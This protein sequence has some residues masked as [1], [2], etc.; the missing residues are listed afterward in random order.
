M[1]YQINRECWVTPLWGIEAVGRVVMV[2]VRTQ[3]ASKQRSLSL[4]WKSGFLVQYCVPCIP[5]LTRSVF[6]LT[7]GW[8]TQCERYCYPSSGWR[9]SV[10]YVKTCH[11][12]F[13][14]NYHGEF[15]PTSGGG[16]TFFINECSL[17]SLQTLPATLNSLT[18]CH[19]D[20][21][22]GEGSKFK[23]ATIEARRPSFLF[24]SA[25]YK[26]I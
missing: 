14:S 16:C 24:R 6:R 4:G 23:F 25:R 15:M 12:S 9:L 26:K 8:V 18:V 21:H 17:G 2:E 13:S 20:M 7:W 3:L 1:E 10:F 11:G 19:W 5:M 22:A